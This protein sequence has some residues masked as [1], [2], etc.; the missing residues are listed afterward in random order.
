MTPFEATTHVSPKILATTF[1]TPRQT[2][3]MTSFFVHDVVGNVAAA[4][5]VALAVGA[6]R[7]GVKLWRNH[8]SRRTP[9]PPE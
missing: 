7:W 1:L 6:W 3:A 4:I 8:T 9:V 5:L 2:E